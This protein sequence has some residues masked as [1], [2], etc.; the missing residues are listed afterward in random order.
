MSNYRQSAV[1]GQ[2]WTRASS[3]TLLNPLNETS[4][5]MFHEETVVAIGDGKYIKQAVGSCSDHFDST[6]A[7]EEFSLIHPVTGDVIGSATY[8]EIYVMMSSLYI[9]IATKRDAA[10]LARRLESP[11]P[12]GPAPSG[13]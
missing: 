8:Q 11:P 2:A 10:E 13:G 1:S 4:V 7:T 6:N 5:G 9:H 12:D 3:V